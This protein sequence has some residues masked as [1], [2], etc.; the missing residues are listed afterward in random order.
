METLNFLQWVSGVGGIGAVFGIIIFWV[1]RETTRQMREDRIIMEKQ[2]REDR[3]FSEERL[4]KIID[5][6]HVTCH[7]D[8]GIMVKHTQVMTELLVYL[9]AKNGH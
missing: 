8:Q 1:Y 2:M 6:Y 3:K 5:D 9:R 7:D 4:V